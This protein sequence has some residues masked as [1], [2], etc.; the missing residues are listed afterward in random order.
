M[1]MQADPFC[2]LDETLLKQQHRS[3]L[4]SFAMSRWLRSA[5]SVI[6]ITLHAVRTYHV[7]CRH[8]VSSIQQHNVLS[9]IMALCAP[10]T[11]RIKY[12]SKYPTWRLVLHDIS[13]TNCNCSTIW[14][15]SFLTLSADLPSNWLKR[16]RSCSF[17]FWV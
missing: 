16:C 11:K 15:L 13:S 7:I 1:F 8:K 10:R 2:Y 14:I 9:N 12:V 6:F 3:S 4:V 5:N 17:V